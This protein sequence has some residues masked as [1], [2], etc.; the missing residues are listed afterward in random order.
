MKPPLFPQPKATGQ[1]REGFGILAKDFSAWINAGGLQWHLLGGPTTGA[2]KNEGDFVM[3]DVEQAYE[4]A[5][6]VVGSA[7]EAYLK[8]VQSFRNNIKNDLASISASADRVQ[9]EQAK[10]KAAYDAATKMLICPEMEKAIANAERLATALAAIS[11]LQ[12]HSI[13]F[14]VLDK[15]PTA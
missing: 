7:Q 4:E 14:A 11:E 3:A 2:M 1:W 5:R 15:K 12:S 6:Q 13:T 8:L 10:M 9:K